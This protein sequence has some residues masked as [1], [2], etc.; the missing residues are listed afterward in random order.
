MQYL[1]WRFRI[2]PKFNVAPVCME[3]ASTNVLTDCDLLLPFRC[4]FDDF[5]MFSFRWLVQLSSGVINLTRCNS[6]LIMDRS[7]NAFCL[8]NQARLLDQAKFLSPVRNRSLSFWPIL[9]MR[10]SGPIGH[11]DEMPSQSYRKCY[12][13]RRM[14]RFT[15]RGP[16]NSGSI[17]AGSLRSEF[18]KPCIFREI[19][20]A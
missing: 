5:S 7:L 1:I 3:S 17:S 20:V 11:N 9:I 13:T 10:Q 16:C 2:A 12:E 18:T 15:A 8:N 6:G 19:V 14:E 4:S